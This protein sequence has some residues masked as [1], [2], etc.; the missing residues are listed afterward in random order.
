VHLE[1]S[2]APNGGRAQLCR[3][4]YLQDDRTQFGN[5]KFGL[6]RVRQYK[7][8]ITKWGLDKNIKS[9]EMDRIVAQGDLGP[10]S[11]IKGQPVDLT[12]IRR[13]LRRK[14]KRREKS[15]AGSP[16]AT[17]AI[18]DVNDHDVEEDA[19]LTCGPTSAHHPD[20]TARTSSDQA[21]QKY[22]RYPKNTRYFLDT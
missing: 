7:R 11:S 9:D 15:E 1:G 22:Y 17:E 21:W 4:V 10:V 8:K 12:K 18:F 14:A 20:D 5:G 13:Y 6:R 2:N 3:Y 19:E 16:S